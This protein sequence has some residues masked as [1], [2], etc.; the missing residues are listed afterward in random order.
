[1]TYLSGLMLGASLA[2]MARQMILGTGGRPAEGNILHGLGGGLFAA[3]ERSHGTHP[4][5]LA[6][7]EAPSAMP[8]SCAV[9]TAVFSCVHASP[10]RRRYR[11]PY[12]T[13]AFATLL[14]ERLAQ[15]P[16][17]SEVRANAV[18]GSILL[19]YQPED[20]AHI[21]VLAEGL[22]AIFSEGR[23]VSHVGTLAQSMRRSVYALSSWIQQHTGGA[24]DLSSLVAGIFVLRG[25]RQLVL[26]NTAPSGSQMLWWALT[27]MRGWRV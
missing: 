19:I 14:E 3:S 27:L 23:N 9:P 26:S 24:L 8:V 17:V 10:G 5:V 21:L 20:E 13:E 16:F 7:T 2:N 12:L 4:H 6:R 22:S 1:M 11:T 25:V 18:S 15:L